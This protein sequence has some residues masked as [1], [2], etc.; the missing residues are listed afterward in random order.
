MELGKVMSS[1]WPM[2]HKGADGDGFG[3]NMGKGIKGMSGDN[4]RKVRD[5]SNAVPGIGGLIS[6]GVNGWGR[7]R[8]SRGQVRT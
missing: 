4:V 1:V 6:R 2:T 3:D 7:V 5:Y 8:K